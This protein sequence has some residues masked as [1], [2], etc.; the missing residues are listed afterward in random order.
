MKQVYKRY[1]SLFTR[2][3]VMDKKTVFTAA[4]NQVSANMSGQAVI[5]N[6]QV[7]EYY[8]LDEVGT[9]IWELIQQPA[10]FEQI[11]SVLMQEYEVGADQCEADL[12]DL[13]KALLDKGLIEVVHEA[14]T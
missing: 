12:R 8:G 14:G 5:L 2:A 4:Q 6:T 10:S 11:Q 1:D 13:L 3:Q 7:G 9:R